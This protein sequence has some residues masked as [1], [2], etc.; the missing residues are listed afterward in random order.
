[1]HRC[2]QWT[3]PYR[4]LQ[5]R[6]W[7]AFDDYGGAGLISITKVNAHPSFESVRSVAIGAHDRTG[8]AFANERARLSARLRGVDQQAIDVSKQIGDYSQEYD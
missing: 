3:R 6:F 5:Q 4:E 7:A 1:M 8:S 2:C